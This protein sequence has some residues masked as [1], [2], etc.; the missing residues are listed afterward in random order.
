MSLIVTLLKL[1][2]SKNR[3]L[4]QDKNT[5]RGQNPV[6]A[7]TV[8]RQILQRFGRHNWATK[9]FGVWKILCLLVSFREINRYC[10]A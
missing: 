7:K 8:L 4:G 10:C 3:K 1:C 5:L 9:G 6:V 2:F